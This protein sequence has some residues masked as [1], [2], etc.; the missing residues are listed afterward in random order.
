MFGGRDKEEEE[1]NEEEEEEDEG[2]EE[3]LFT[4]RAEIQTISVSRSLSFPGNCEQVSSH[5]LKCPQIV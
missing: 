5:I 4:R 2:D 1:E 3:L